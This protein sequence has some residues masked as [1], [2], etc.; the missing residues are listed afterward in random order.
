MITNIMNFLFYFSPLGTA[1]YIMYNTYMKKQ[2]IKE[3]E[4]LL[5]EKKKILAY[6]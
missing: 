6:Y 1:C 4:D 2:F 5:L 3:R